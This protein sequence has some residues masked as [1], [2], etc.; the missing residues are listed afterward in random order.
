MNI[1]CEDSLLYAR[2]F[3]CDWGEVR[4]F[5]GRTVKPDDIQDA[6]ILLVRSTTQ[7]N[8]SLIGECKQLQFVGTGTAGFNHLDTAY[9]TIRELPWCA[10]PGC[11]A[12]AVAEY[13]VSA[14]FS[15]ADE[16]NWELSE[17]T[18]GIVGA[19]NVGTALSGK[20]EA[21]G[22][23]YLLCD[24]PLAESDDPR[25]FVGM[26]DIM[27]CDIISL[28]VPLIE[29]DPFPTMHLFDEPLLASLDPQQVLINACRGEVINNRALLELCRDG[30]FP[31]LVM[32]V[33]E[34]EP[35]IC[36]ELV[37]YTQLATAHIAGHTLEGKA[38]GTEMLYQHLAMLLNKPVAHKLADFLPSPDVAELTPDTTLASQQA[39]SGLV[40]SVYDI[41]RDDAHF[42][43]NVDSSEQFEYTRKHY[44][45]RREF[46]SASVSTGNSSMTKAILGL[47][48][49]VNPAK[50]E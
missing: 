22:I 31:M 5:S 14:L 6:D 4:L 26:P 18:V 7:V 37:P 43:A 2:E 12:L 20:L 24:P 1:Y 41:R 15:L 33:W 47:G 44:A 29:S 25:D 28:H 17:K 35:D 3:F 10:A 27:A 16:Q 21:L 13:V 30:S 46:A 36:T 40:F 23:E 38:R 8:Q 48:F 9:L 19:G 50:G 42:R 32:D 45:I 34:H 39:L 11:N 49:S